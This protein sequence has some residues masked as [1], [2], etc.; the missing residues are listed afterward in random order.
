MGA[1]SKRNGLVKKPTG[2]LWEIGSNWQLYIMALPAVIWFGIFSYYPLMF[3]Q[4]AFKDYNIMD[5]AFGSPYLK[6]L[7][8]NF[9]Y[10]F[11][12][13]YF[14]RTTFNTLYL[15]ILS[16][17]FVTLTAVTVALLLN[18]LRS[19]Y[20]K[21]IF[22]STLFLPYFLSTIIVA[23]F[24]YALLG[25]QFG[26]LNQ[27]LKSI[28]M[29]PIALYTMP[30]VWPGILTALAVFQGAGF[31][32]VIYLAV[33]T[34]IDS[35]L[36]EAAKIDGAGRWKEIKYITIPHLL[37]TVFILFLLAVGK[38]FAGNFGL[39]YS[40]VGNN[41]MLFPTTDVLDTYVYRGLIFD[42]TISQSTAVGLYQ[43]VM[44]VITV[45]LCNKLVKKYDN[46]YGLF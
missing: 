45:L 10:F 5:G 20:A 15:N 8:Y 12:S 13:I 4:I 43:S 46:S 40:I 35:E 42:G 37:P 19:N 36:Y 32:S 22:Q 26:T 17:V 34:S 31:N 11:T 16:I 21:K 3:L 18:E 27:I 24:V 1:L 29:Q 14:A 9:K 41:G 7:F 30:Q 25:D 23:T 33:I 39:I 2:F 38:I 44:G 28:G 6:D